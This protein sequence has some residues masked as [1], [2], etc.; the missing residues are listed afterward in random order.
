MK[1]KLDQGAYMP[2]RA[3]ELD[4][5]YDLRT[6]G[7]FV[8]GSFTT[9]NGDGMAMIDTG[10]HVEIPAGHVG[11]LKSKSGLNVHHNLTCDGTIDAGY[12]GSI[13][14][15][16]YNHGPEPYTFQR[17]DK[18]AQLVIVPIV[19]PDLEQVQDLA[20]TERGSNGFGSTGR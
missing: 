2:E 4:A 15:K 13:I 1:V 3:H 6:P 14:V 16:I 5:G 20:E 7:R 8:V 10:I 12:T 17:G 18:V 11:F 9:F 19:T